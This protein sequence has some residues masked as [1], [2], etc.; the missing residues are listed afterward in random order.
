MVE[1]VRMHRKDFAALLLGAA[2]QWLSR[3]ALAEHGERVTVLVANPAFSDAAYAQAVV[4]LQR[5]ESEE[6][7][8]ILNR[9]SELALVL[10]RPGELAEEL[11]RRL[12]LKLEVPADTL[13]RRDAAGL[14][15]E[16]LLAAQALRT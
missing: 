13:S 6:V 9:P 12:W 1:I 3:P 4:V 11:K 2:A 8:V 16:L 10:W 7:G 15:D 5:G 14:R